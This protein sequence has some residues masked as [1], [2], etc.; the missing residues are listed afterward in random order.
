M[1]TAVRG[2]P[3]RAGRIALGSALVLVLAAG[4][5][6]G[7]DAAG[8][9]PGGLFAD[10]TP[11]PTATPTSTPAPPPAEPVL[12]P[13]SGSPGGPAGLDER[14]LDDPDLG[15]DAGAFVVDVATGEVLLDQDAASARTPASVAKLATAAAA[16]VTLGPTARLETRTV[17]GA[18]PGN[19]VLVGAGDTTLTVQTTTDRD[20][21]R[22]ASLTELADETAAVLR[23]KGVVEVT[24]QVDDSLF[25]GP[26]V[27]PDWEPG[28][29]GAGVV[30]PVSALTL[31]GGRV[32]PGAMSRVTDPAVSAGQ[33][34]ARLLTARGFT[35]R[36]QVTRATAPTTAQT[37]GAVSSPEMSS[38]VET[39]LSTSDNDLAEA[40]LRL[41]AA[42]GDEPATFEGG[43]AAVGEVL[44]ELAVP[45]DGLVLLDGS[46]LAR[47][48]RIA[49][50]T[51]GSLLALAANGADPRL[52]PLV[53][54]LPVAAF[55]GTLADRFGS[56]GARDGAGVVRAKTGTL[57]GV[58][59]LA[60]V[61]ARS[62]EG[63]DK[64]VRLI[65]FAL[66]SDDVAAGETLSAR[67]ALDRIAAGLARPDG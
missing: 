53:T 66:L 35:V 55:S 57:T 28:Y 16:L 64:S 65:A 6:V 1:V 44:T 7:L 32:R 39:M 40:L 11:R 48:S 58:A 36:G 21:P 17:L 59:A 45:S 3:G 27:S 38:L 63:S 52:R 18:A 10:P 37:L 41:V 46:G 13:A 62:D 24:V 5:V 23:L 61:V 51:L 29:I 19:V 14:L 67:G 8:Q 50:E 4:A 9:V 34:L 56:D 15:G 33:R 25:S 47:G 54:G 60:G 2:R 26:A 42:S 31:D 30:S 49:P 12:A 20:Y 43:S 22:P